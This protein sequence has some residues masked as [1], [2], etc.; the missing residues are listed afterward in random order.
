WPSRVTVRLRFE[1]R[2]LEGPRHEPQRAPERHQRAQ[3]RE[4]AI[5]CWR[6]ELA[7]REVGAVRK[8]E[9]IPVPGLLRAAVARGVRPPCGAW[10]RV[11]MQSLVVRLAAPTPPTPQRRRARARLHT[12]PILRR[13]MTMGPRRRREQWSL[14]RGVLRSP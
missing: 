13:P 11:I 3:R 14:T 2:H 9:T 1:S 12:L 6:G 5:H 4:P 7:V 10:W 8:H